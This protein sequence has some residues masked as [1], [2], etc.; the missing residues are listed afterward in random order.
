[1]NRFYKPADLR[2]LFESKADEISPGDFIIKPQNKELKEMWCAL[3][4]GVGYEKLVGPCTVC[5][6]IEEN[7]DA[8][9]IIKTFAGEFPFQTIIADVPG[10][11]MGDD[12]KPGPGG[13]LPKRP[14]QPERGRIEGPGWITNAV[15]EK[16][17]KRYSTAKNLNLLIYANFTAHHMSYIDVYKA[18]EPYNDVFAS[19]WIITNH[20]ICS[21]IVNNS[22]GKIAQFSTISEE[23][24]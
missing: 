20:Q 24:D 16:I 12:Y 22:L 18:I 13:N 17:K 21:L 6:E 7:N 1:M 5:V 4:F 19:I 3:R 23:E 11:H 2:I 9:F 8:D 15:K 14:Y 10:R